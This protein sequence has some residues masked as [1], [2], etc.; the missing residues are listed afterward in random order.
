MN[1][2]ETSGRHGNNGWIMT[3]NLNQVVTFAS[4]ASILLIFILVNLL[5]QRKHEDF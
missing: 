2:L 1:G 5:H 3:N 4:T